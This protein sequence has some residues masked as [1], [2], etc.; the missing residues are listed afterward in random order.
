M[1]EADELLIRNVKSMLT[2]KY[3]KM[4]DTFLR[5][6]INYFISEHDSQNINE[7]QD[8]V[9]AQWQLNDLR[10]INT[11]NGIF[12][13]N[14]VRQEITT[15]TGTYNVQ[16]DKMYDISVSKLKQIHEIRNVSNFNLE[17][18]EAQNNESRD[19]NP[20]PKRMYQF[21]LTDGIQ[22]VIAI[23]YKPLRQ[24]KDVLLPGIKLMIIGP[25]VCRKGVILL[26][27]K[28]IKEIGGEIENLL[29]PNALEN[30]LARSL[31]LPENPNPYKENETPPD[32]LE[33]AFE[34]EFNVDD[35]INIENENTVNNYSASTTNA[36][37]DTSTSN[38][39]NDQNKDKNN[40]QVT[41]LTNKNTYRNNSNDKPQMQ[42]TK[43]Q[44]ADEFPDD[45]DEYFELADNFDIDVTESDMLRNTG[46]K[47]AIEPR[48]STSTKAVDLLITSDET[49]SMKVEDNKYLVDDIIQFSDDDFELCDNVEIKQIN[50]IERK[51]ENKKE[52]SI[53]VEF[54]D[55]DFEWCDNVVMQQINDIERE[56]ENKEETGILKK[57]NTGI[58]ETSTNV[59]ELSQLSLNN[60]KTDSASSK[61]T[62]S[63]GS[64]NPIIS[65]VTKN[66][67]PASMVSPTMASPP[68]VK[69]VQE[70]PKLSKIDK[71]I[72]N[73][74]VKLKLDSEEAP[75]THISIGDVLMLPVSDC[76]VRHIIK[77]K[78]ASFDTLGKKN[79][80]WHLEATLT[81]GS[82]NI[83]ITF[84]S[85]V[86]ERIIGFGVDKF[87]E[88]KKKGK[89]DPNIKAE[90]RQALRKAEMFVKQLDSL[91]ELEWSKD[92]KP[93]VIKI[94]SNSIDE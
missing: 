34:D 43:I 41:L 72:T 71:K 21:F 48:P 55:D 87:S 78:V 39:F 92:K 8:F 62:T 93:T 24:F 20:K 70:T 10:E 22:D 47:S 2:A 49:K 91:M 17:V 35:I 1:G 88:M 27:E 44:N 9:I 56:I 32:N 36:H 25:V 79:N 23:E 66:K 68:K 4:N 30:V 13:S 40:C 54:F 69:C 67:R 37:T 29:I 50:D 19:W 7:I 11:E 33:S 3:Y 6:C 51:I 12:P 31:N 77:A 64:S 76:S 42:N 16:M 57:Q 52:P 18:T 5:D 74:T 86:L 15:L 59:S 84:A 45:L 65:T 46:E 26:E 94:M 58:Q 61:P 53:G 75:K 63:S 73:F 60:T 89:A 82:K 85:E 83:D 38:E 90:L 80:C 28:N 81:D 14:L